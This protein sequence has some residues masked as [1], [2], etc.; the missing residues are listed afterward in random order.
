MAVSLTFSANTIPNPLW[1][2]LEHNL[3]LPFGLNLHIQMKI[4]VAV[5]EIY[6]RHKIGDREIMPTNGRTMDPHCR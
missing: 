5:V 6:Q 3:E 4:N 1:R 2:K